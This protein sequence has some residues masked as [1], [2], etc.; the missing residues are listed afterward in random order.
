MGI[1]CRLWRW[2]T[3]PAMEAFHVAF[4]GK[5]AA[6][7]KY[8]RPDRG[9]LK[10]DRPNHEWEQIPYVAVYG[11]YPVSKRWYIRSDRTST[12][13]AL[14]STA[15]GSQTKPRPRLSVTCIYCACSARVHQALG[16]SKRTMDGFVRFSTHMI[17]THCAISISGTHAVATSFIYALYS[18]QVF[19]PCSLPCLQAVFSNYV[20]ISVA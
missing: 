18:T 4:A 14:T 9:K 1:L 6:L 10:Y 15:K 12:R 16:R 20:F 13:Y 7:P 8:Q 5:L 3:V 11:I 19:S 2:L 17:R